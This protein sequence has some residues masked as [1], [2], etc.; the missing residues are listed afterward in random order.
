[1]KKEIFPLCMVCSVV[2]HWRAFIPFFLG[3]ILLGSGCQRNDAEI[4]AFRLL[5]SLNKKEISLVGFEKVTHQMEWEGSEYDWYFRKIDIGDTTIQ[6][7]TQNSGELSNVLIY[8]PCNSI[9]NCKDVVTSWLG[10]RLTM[11]LDTL[12]F[13]KLSIASVGEFRFPDSEIVYKTFLH[14]HDNI[15]ESGYGI[16]MSTRIRTP[17][18][19]WT[20]MFDK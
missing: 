13:Q 3:L 12:D 8:I 20:R 14:H 16:R 10:D 9:A 6:I 7:F 2:N 15:Y 17:D 19:G 18:Q 5:E 11:S 4:G 1:M